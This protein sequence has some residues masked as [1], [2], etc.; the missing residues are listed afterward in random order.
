MKANPFFETFL[1]DLM[2]KGKVL[3]NIVKANRSVERHYFPVTEENKIVVYKTDSEASLNNPTIEGKGLCYDS[4]SKTPIFLWMEG[5]KFA[6]PL[7]MKDYS[8][9]AISSDND[10]KVYNLGKKIERLNNPAD[11]KKKSAQDLI[12]VAVG[13]IAILCI[14][15]IVLTFA[16]ADKV[17]IKFIG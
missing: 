8:E 6:Y 13:I 16:V 10:F 12:L 4:D 2:Y 5:D 17:G 1:F 11:L 14:V 3:V 15:N 7:N 9:K